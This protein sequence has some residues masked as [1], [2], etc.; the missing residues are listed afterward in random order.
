MILALMLRIGLIAVVLSGCAASTLVGASTVTAAALGTSALERKAGGCYAMC[1]GS[2]MCN[3]RTGLCEEKP[4]G[5]LCSADQHCEVSATKS[6][7]APGPPGDVAAKAPGSETKI[8]VLLPP[9][10]VSGGPPQIVPAAEQNP[11]SHK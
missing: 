3:P 6:W 2:T 11:P 8:P 1:T 10:G 5:G 4:C 7:C 9:P